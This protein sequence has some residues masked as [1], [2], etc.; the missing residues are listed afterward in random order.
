M[1]QG[2][3]TLYLAAATLVAV[4]AVPAWAQT[5]AVELSGRYQAIDD[6]SIGETFP[7]GWSADA[8]VT[9]TPTWSAVGEV[10]GAYRKT[11]DLG[12]ALALHTFGGGARWSPWRTTHFV[13]F[14][15]FV[16][17]LARMTSTITIGPGDIR[18]S[19]T[20]FMVQPAGGV[21]VAVGRGWGITSQLGYRRIVLDGDQDGDTGFN[22]ITA[23]AGVRFGF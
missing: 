16:V 3:T 7:A 21:T 15:Q 9:I 5:P 12:I 19:Q 10:G 22:E 4:I 8:A 1:R 14:A 18:M 20:K 11:G 13:P 2:H 23:S 17:G 6:R